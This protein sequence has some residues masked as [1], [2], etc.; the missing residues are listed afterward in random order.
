MSRSRGLS[1]APIGYLS[2]LLR[3]FR[4]PNGSKLGKLFVLAVAVY[5]IFPIDFIPDFAPVIGWL[6]DLGAA[7]LA[8]AYLISVARKY[9][10]ASTREAYAEVDGKKVGAEVLQAPA[11][12]IPEYDAYA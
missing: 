7:G 12:E 11:A 4:D 1:R 2:A 6:D 5:V 9:R 3:F 8:T 10:D